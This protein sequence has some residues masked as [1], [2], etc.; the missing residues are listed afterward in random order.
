MHLLNKD[1]DV[2][3]LC[4]EKM[5]AEIRG[6]KFHSGPMVLHKGV[7]LNIQIGAMQMYFFF[8]CYFPFKTLKRISIYMVTYTRK[9]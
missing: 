5:G 6:Q 2:Y 3:F 8:T 7:Q 9:D 4:T 1:A